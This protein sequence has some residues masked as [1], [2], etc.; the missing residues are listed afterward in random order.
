MGMYAAFWTEVV[1]NVAGTQRPHLHSLG[2]GT[3]HTGQYHRNCRHGYYHVLAAISRP[4]ACTD[5]PAVNHDLIGSKTV[6][7]SQLDT[8]KGM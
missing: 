4:Q 3:R 2:A 7:G 8:V 5:C 6:S 1:N